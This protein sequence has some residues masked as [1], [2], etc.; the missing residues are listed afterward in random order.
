[1]TRCSR[2][3]RNCRFASPVPPHPSPV[4]SQARHNMDA[5]VWETAS[6]NVVPK[7]R[8]TAQP[9]LQLLAVQG[10][11]A[12]V[13]GI[14][15]ILAPAQWLPKPATIWV[16]QVGK[17]RC[18]K[19]S[20]RGGE[21]KETSGSCGKWLNSMAVAR[22]LGGKK[23]L[24]RYRYCN[25]W[26]ILRSQPLQWPLQAATTRYALPVKST[27][28]QEIRRAKAAACRQGNGP[29]KL[30]TAEPYNWGSVF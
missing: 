27:A 22:P 15:R 9:M 17:P 3:A 28:G 8:V 24:H 14:R 10:L 1:M 26:L 25:H 11:K 4:A 6:R 13:H 18:G 12:L 5:P 19:W 7:E 20:S 29:W 16:P 21:G 30:Q 23:P 2:F